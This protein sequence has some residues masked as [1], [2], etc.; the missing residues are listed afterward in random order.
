MVDVSMYGPGAALKVGYMNRSGG[1][2]PLCHVGTF[3]GPAPTVVSL[4]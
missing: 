4:Y 3:R 1:V 2:T